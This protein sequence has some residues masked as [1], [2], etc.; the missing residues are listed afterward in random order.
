MGVTQKETISVYEE[1]ER[2]RKKKSKEESKRIW[3]IEKRTGK[4]A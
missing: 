4:G 2:E 3:E 1:R